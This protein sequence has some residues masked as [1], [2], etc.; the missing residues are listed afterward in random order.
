[1]SSPTF[2]VIGQDINRVEGR[3]KVTGRATYAAD[4]RFPNLAYAF[5]VLSTV[6]SGQIAAIE[7]SEA[8]A[9][10]G[11]LGVWSHARP[12]RIFRSPADPATGT[13]VGEARPPFDDDRVYYYG[14]YVAVVVATTFEQARAAARL[15]QVRYHD[16]GASAMAVT[17]DAALAAHGELSRGGDAK[18]GDPDPTWQAA[19]VKID[20]TYTT[21][22]EVHHPLELHATVAYWQGDDV[23]LHDSTQSIN[24]ERNAIAKILGVPIE[25][26]TVKAPYIGGGFGGKLFMWN[27]TVIAGALARELG[28]PI[29]LYVERRHQSTTVGHRP[30]TRQRLRLAADREGKLLAIRHDTHS[31][32]SLVDEFQEGCGNVTRALY[33]VAHLGVTHRMVPA[34]IGTPTSMRAPGAAPGLFALESAVDE[35]ALALNLDPIEF[36]LRN[37]PT[38]DP[39]KKLPWSSNHFPECFAVGRERFG[40]DRRDPRPGS[41]RDGTDILGWGVAGASW[42]AH[43]GVCAARAEFRADGILRVTCGTQDIG[44]GTYTVIAQVAAEITTVPIARIEVVL[45]DTRLPQGPNS[46]GSQVT[47]TVIPAVAEAARNVTQALFRVTTRKQGPLAGHD[48]AKLALRGG[49][50]VSTQDSAVRCEI[51]AALAACRLG[52]ID[53]EGKGGPS[54]DAQ[55]YAFRCFG[56]HFAEVRW[57]PGLARLRISRVVSVLDAG[58]IINAKTARS[59]IHGALIMGLGMT[60]MEESIYDPHTGRVVNDNFADYHIPCHADT[61]EMDVVFLDHPDPHLGEFG[62]RGIGELGITGITAAIANA[63]H[64]ATGRRIRDLPITIDKLLA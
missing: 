7:T 9:L 12:L 30:F 50:I 34:H 31:L 1:M 14:Q 43:R 10:P 39:E 28:R 21:A 62:A 59:Q 60:L 64:H 51:G 53:A 6:A 4:H 46:G 26:V 24:G 20:V 45:G 11:V 52:S 38:V 18:R 48:P 27:H 47:A 32:T 33:D 29:K 8:L 55:K 25:R 22:P 40:W 15:V 16:E 13:K 35:L 5:G 63:V 49:Q 37:L 61:P 56:A 23:V 58:R 41:M 57:D 2:Q 42:G 3:V 54:P 19:P 44:T 17:I 36:R